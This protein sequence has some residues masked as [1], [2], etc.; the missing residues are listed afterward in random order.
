MYL[1]INSMSSTWKT[2]FL[3]RGYRFLHQICFI[4]Y[5]QSGG[6]AR[7]FGQKY[8]C[9]LWVECPCLYHAYAWWWA[10]HGR[11]FCM[12]N[13]AMPKIQHRANCQAHPLLPVK[14]RKDQLDRY[15]TISVS[16]DLTKTDL[17]IDLINLNILNEYC[18]YKKVGTS[19][20]F[21]Q[22]YLR[23]A[24]WFYI[25]KTSLNRLSELES[26]L[27]TPLHIDLDIERAYPND[28]KSTQMPGTDVLLSAKDEGFSNSKGG[29]EARQTP[30]LWS[31]IRSKII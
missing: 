27:I 19:S 22:S 29:Q 10:L 7:K 24:S 30:L 9:C 18:V 3:V 26:G 28:K 14:C 17:C 11:E 12:G 5:G 31:I 25:G 23:W 4:V 21:F 6:E 13:N 8:D 15:V 1:A 16:N 20:V 2:I